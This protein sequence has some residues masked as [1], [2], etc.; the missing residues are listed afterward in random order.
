MNLVIKK[1]LIVLIPFFL[2]A[3]MLIIGL[4]LNLIF[5]KIDQNPNYKKDI[6]IL[7]KL[8]NSY[9]QV[10]IDDY[11]KV[12]DDQSGYTT[13]EGQAYS[14]LRSLYTEDQQMFDKV[15]QWSK[16]HLQ[17]RPNDKL[18]S[19]KYGLQNREYKVLDPQ[20][21]TDAD[22]DIAYALLRAGKKWKVETYKKEAIELI[23]N[24]WSLRVVKHNN[25]FFLLPFNS[26]SYDGYEI[27]NP[28]YFAP[29]YY[30]EF[31]K[32][33]DL[34]Q[35]QQWLKLANDTYQ[36]LQ[37]IKENRI[38]YPDWIKYNITKNKFETAQF[39]LNNS[40]SDNFSFDAIRII[41]RIG[42]DYQQNQDP[43]AHKILM[44]IAN[45]LNLILDTNEIK[46][47]INK[48]GNSTLNYSTPSIN[49]MSSIALNTLNSSNK[50][51]IWTKEIINFTNFESG[52][53]KIKMSYY[54]QNLIW[55]A[56]AYDLKVYK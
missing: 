19:W 37:M 5:N 42:Q 28:S 13:S 56:Y 34:T 11:G 14:M 25:Q 3:I 21:A 24:I 6:T 10:F 27:L 43:N 4:K 20:N 8:N 44:T 30:K 48:E 33:T 29:M 46:S 31:A 17:T 39:F 41:L 49:A 7:K 22:L 38:L 15:Y 45:E 12:T 16:I 55:F 54:D 51:K 1:S 47:S 2:L 52:T 40:N 23:N 32:E 9:N 36:Q 26:N 50:D 35:N 18:F 53:F